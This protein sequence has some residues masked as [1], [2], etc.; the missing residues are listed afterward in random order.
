LRH[1][2]DFRCD[3]VAAFCS[4]RHVS[5]SVRGDNSMKTFSG[6]AAALLLAATVGTGCSG[7]GKCDKVVDKMGDFAMQMAEQ[8]ACAMGGEGNVDEMKKKMKEDFDKEKPEMVKK[9]NEALEKDKG[10]EKAL[11]CVIAADNME[12]AMKCEGID[13]LK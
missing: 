10:A 5:Q 3:R 8:M 4:G 1:G 9:C 12:A 2:C 6:I 11:D 7:G 13:A